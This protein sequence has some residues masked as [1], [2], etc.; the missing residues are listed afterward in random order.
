MEIEVKPGKA[1]V[2]AAVA[3]GGKLLT[4]STLPDVTGMTNGQLKHVVHF[5]GKA[6]ISW[7]QWFQCL[8]TAK[9]KRGKGKEN[10]HLIIPSQVLLE[11]RRRTAILKGG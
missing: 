3:V 4:W 5:N 7:E 2:D 8:E 10:P 9:K 11:T 6:R 1:V